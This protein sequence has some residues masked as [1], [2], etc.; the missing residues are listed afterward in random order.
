MSG[1]APQMLDGSTKNS[2]PLKQCSTPG[3][4]YKEPS[5]GIELTK[6]KWVCSSCWRA[7][8]SRKK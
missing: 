2:H 1:Q 6:T 7:R 3:C 8:N 5:G 4:G